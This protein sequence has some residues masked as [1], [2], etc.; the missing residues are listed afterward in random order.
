METGNGVVRKHGRIHATDPSDLALHI[1]RHA[2][3]GVAFLRGRLLHPDVA[4]SQRTMRL[5]IRRRER[6]SPV[7]HARRTAL[8]F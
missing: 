1:D 2:E 8:A 5:A 4:S 7:T 3:R 6:P